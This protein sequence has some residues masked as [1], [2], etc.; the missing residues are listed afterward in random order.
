MLGVENVTS[1]SACFNRFDNFNS[2]VTRK[3]SHG[4]LRQN[5]NEF[6][7]LEWKIRTITVDTFSCPSFHYYYNNYDTIVLLNKP[8]SLKS[9]SVP[10]ILFFFFQ[11]RDLYVLRTARDEITTQ[12]ILLITFLFKF[13]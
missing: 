9:S 8:I 5:E 7:V 2:Y 12:S 1:G 6:K 10:R 11:S 3:L 13:D 4:K